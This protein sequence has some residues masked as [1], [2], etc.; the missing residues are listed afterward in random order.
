VIRIGMSTTCV[1]PW[2]TERA[3]TIAKLAGF[4]G[5][6]VMVTRDRVTQDADAL[7][8]LAEEHELPILSVHA[9]VLLL[10]QFVWGTDPRGKLERTAELAGRLGAPTVV[11][12]PPFSWQHRYAG[13][14]LEAVSDIARASGIGIAVEN[15]FP[16]TVRGR[17]IG[18]YAPGWN[19]AEWDCDAVTL[20]F[21]HAALS[22]LDALEVA[23]AL[24]PRLRHLH[25]CDGAA[26]VAGATAFDEHL[27][28]GHGTQPVA[29]TLRLL[30]GSGWSGSVVAEVNTRRLRTDEER[31]ALLRSTLRFA[32]EQVAA[33]A[34]SRPR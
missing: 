6:E 23:R 33:G 26:P 34:P 10:T 14:F 2:S 3:F 16:W 29:E 32:R 5:V 7:A 13:H 4:D 1:Y 19:P 11:V 22:G 27:P 15:M 20:D 18:A 12:H 9:P 28:P 31:L 21:S 30:A 8:R 24:G 17:S 25:L